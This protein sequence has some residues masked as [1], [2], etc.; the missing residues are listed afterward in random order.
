MLSN[1]QSLYIFHKGT[2]IIVDVICKVNH[3]YSWHS[4]PNVNGRAAGNISI[5]SSIILCGGTLEKFSEMFKTAKIPFISHT[6]FY[7]I[8][9]KLV[10]PAIHQVFTT[11][12]QLLFDEAKERGSIDLLIIIRTHN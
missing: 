8:Q 4:Q 2:K 1:S 7:R 10:I 12:R 5:A 11:Q 3:K 6:T 9:K